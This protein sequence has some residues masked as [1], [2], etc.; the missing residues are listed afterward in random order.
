MLPVSFRHQNADRILLRRVQDAPRSSLPDER[1]LVSLR[2]CQLFSVIQKPANPRHQPPTW[3]RGWK[4]LCVERGRRFELRLWGTSNLD[5]EVR[6]ARARTGAF[7]ALVVTHPVP[8][9]TFSPQSSPRFF[10]YVITV[11]AHPSLWRVKN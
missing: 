11:D 3:R 2:C 4:V 5:S 10:A 1:T 6:A 8:R 9:R 7:K